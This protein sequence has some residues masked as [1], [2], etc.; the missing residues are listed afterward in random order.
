MLVAFAKYRKFVAAAVGAV[1]QVIAL[2]VLSG[3][4]L[5]DAQIALAALTA[6][7]VLL[8]PNTAAAV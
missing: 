2:N 5:H 6:L 8:T 7:V 3:T 1:T 4:A